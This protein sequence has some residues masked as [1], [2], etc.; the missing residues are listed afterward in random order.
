MTA[1][2]CVEGFPAALA[3]CRS[4]DLHRV[5]GG[6]TLFHIPGARGRALFVSVLLHGN[7]DTGFEAI[8]IIMARYATSGLPRPLVLFIGNV[9]AAAANLRSLPGQVDYNRAWPGTALVGTP[10]AAL[11]AEVVERVRA[12]QPEFSIDIHNNT[13]LNPHYGCINRLDDRYLHLA[14]LFSRTIVYFTEPHGV[15][16]AALAPLCPA[17]TVECGKA[18]VAANTAHAV[19]FVDAC[20]HLSELP[21][22]PL[23]A[24]DLD[25]LRTGWI[26]RVPSAASLSFDGSAADFVFRTDLDHLNFSELAPGTE[27]ARRRPGA[28]HRLEIV[29]GGGGHIDE[30]FGYAGDTV[31]LARA[32]IPAMLTLDANAV[33]LDCLCYLMQRIDRDGRPA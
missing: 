1:L 3:A 21:S 10:E 7:E 13:G 15:Q 2:R 19:D 33:R 12:C 29:D 9:A 5:L 8:K 20:L 11:M 14:R 18:G 6:P 22:A 27:F 28:D 31:A 16:S 25:L 32:A 4:G 30:V 24:Q 17:V 26:V 23:A